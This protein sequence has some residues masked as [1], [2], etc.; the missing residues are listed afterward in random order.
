MKNAKGQQA[1]ILFG[2]SWDA[3]VE[4]PVVKFEILSELIRNEVLKRYPQQI[5]SEKIIYWTVLATVMRNSSPMLCCLASVFYDTADLSPQSQIPAIQVAV[6]HCLS[7]QSRTG[8]IITCRVIVL[9]QGKAQ[10]VETD[11]LTPTLQLI[12]IAKLRIQLGEGAASPIKTVLM[13]HAAD[14]ESILLHVSEH[15][16]LEIVDPH[17]LSL[18]GLTAPGFWASNNPTRKRDFLIPAGIGLL[19][20]VL[21]LFRQ[22]HDQDVVLASQKVELSGL[23]KTLGSYQAVVDQ[24]AV[25]QKEFSALPLPMTMGAYSLLAAVATSFAE[26]DRL[27]YLRYDGLSRTITMSC[28]SRD[29]IKYLKK[30]SSLPVLENV[31]STGMIPLPDGS[32]LQKFQWSGVIKK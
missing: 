22:V 19:L 3:L 20:L 10:I 7:H 14:R 6:R 9:N 13:S 26:G 28:V 27:I 21:L 16:G 32:G 25:L 11:A 18:V 5:P 31:S 1:E 30:V 23:Q 2:S 17:S 15:A 4:V 12:P 8:A 29:P 24:I